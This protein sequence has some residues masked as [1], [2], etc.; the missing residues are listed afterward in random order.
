MTLQR[1]PSIVPGRANWVESALGREL[2]SLCAASR[3]GRVVVHERG[4][5]RGQVVVLN[6]QVG[7]AVAINQAQDLGCFLQ[8]LGK[9][10]RGDLAAVRRRFQE[11]G[12]RR[13]F[14]ALL[15]EAGLIKR[16]VLRRCLMLHTRAALANLL[17]GVQEATVDVEPV[18]LEADSEMTFA[19]GEIMQEEFDTSSRVSW[20]EFDDWTSDNEV[21]KPLSLV[22]GYRAS[23]VLATD[24][25]VLIAQS[26]S[27]R[28]DPS[29]IA[30]FLATVLEYATYAMTGV[31]A[32]RLA[33]LE[34]EEGSIIA[35]WID[36]D[37]TRL[38]AL[39]L[40]PDGSLGMAKLRMG[41]LVAQL[42][43]A[44]RRQSC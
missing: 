4:E 28:S 19:L 32:V 43:P 7:W 29:L 8:R 30:I 25:R 10:S 11:L 33:L 20:S 13:K 22:P 35:R 39:L 5:V 41:E 42:E 2:R 26:I 3:S 40:E 21:L 36:A 31:G 23:A 34:C 37:S 24:G 44:V 17:D 12:G 9:V 38:L 16:P 1:A 14:G 15:E 6:G 27:A 18:Q